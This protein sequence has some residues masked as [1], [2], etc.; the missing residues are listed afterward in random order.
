MEESERLSV[1]AA[2]ARVQRDEKTVRRWIRQ[3]WLKAE[4]EETPSGHAYWIRP[5]DL[6]E[7]LARATR[8]SAPRESLP[9]RVSPDVSPPGLSQLVELVQEQTVLLEAM[10]AELGALRDQVAEMQKGQTM[11]AAPVP[12]RRPWW[13]FWRR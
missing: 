10:R 2:A 12:V 13:R 7:G 8:V 3:G 11:L 1:R 4:R 5:A 6:V 9:A